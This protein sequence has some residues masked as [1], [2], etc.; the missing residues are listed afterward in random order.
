ML[1]PLCLYIDKTG[2]DKV[3]KNSLEPLV[4]VSTVLNIEARRQCNHWFV[5]GLIPNLDRSSAATRRSFGQR[6]LTKSI[7]IREYHHCLSVLLQPLI[8]LQKEM[9]V[10]NVRRGQHV[11]TFRMIVPIACTLGDNLSQ[12]QLV[13]RVK[14]TKQTMRASRYCY[15]TFNQSDHIPHKCHAVNGD[16]IRAL[17]MAALGCQYGTTSPTASHRVHSI[18]VSP[19]LDKWNQYVD[20]L[21]NKNG[22][23]SKVAKFDK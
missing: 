3:M 7:N 13:G 4:A 18:P 10:M 12:N 17:S 14:N 11:G 23:T 15:T 1:S 2:T 5:V 21:K 20:S 22:G 6:N 9:P 8:N 19:N 16:H